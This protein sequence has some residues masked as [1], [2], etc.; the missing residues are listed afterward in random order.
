[1]GREGKGGRGAGRGWVGKEGEG[2]RGEE[3]EGREYHHFFL[4]TLSTESDKRSAK[5]TFLAEVRN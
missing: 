2:K 1:M 3:K 5:H 4:Y